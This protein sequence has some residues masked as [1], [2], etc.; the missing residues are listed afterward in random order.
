LRNHYYSLKR[1]VKRRNRH[2]ILAVV[3]FPVKLLSTILLHFFLPSIE[4]CYYFFKTKKNNNFQNFLNYKLITK[5]EML[6]FI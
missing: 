6:L 2:L 5:I 1:N 4:I 3:D